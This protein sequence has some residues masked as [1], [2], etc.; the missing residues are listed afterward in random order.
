MNEEA[1]AIN[2]SLQSVGWLAVLGGL[3]GLGQLLAS[4]EK[5]TARIVIGRFLSS[6]GIGAAAA[7]PL[8]IM[9]DMPF[10]AQ[11]ALAAGLAS[12]GTSAL[13]RLVQRVFNIS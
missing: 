8:A 6:A 7:L 3:V 4:Q 1:K 11:L 5:L 13:E 12:L 9:P 10:G 2:D